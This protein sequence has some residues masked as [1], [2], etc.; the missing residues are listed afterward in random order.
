MLIHFKYFQEKSQEDLE[1]YDKLW[2]DN[3]DKLIFFQHGLPPSNQLKHIFNS[4]DNNK[5]I[6]SV[7]FITMS[8]LKRNKIINNLI[9]GKGIEYNKKVWCPKE[10]WVYCPMID[11]KEKS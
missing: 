10:V 8:K 7:R 6:L 2:N 5:E 4:L 11:Y 3:R 1:K 9:L